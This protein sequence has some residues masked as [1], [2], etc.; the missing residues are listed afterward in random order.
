MTSQQR[1]SQTERIR[2]TDAQLSALE[3]SG[4]EIIDRDA[5]D[6]EDLAVLAAAWTG[7]TLTVTDATRESLWRAI[8]D[9]SNAEDA[10][11]E[12]DNDP[13]MRTFARRASRSLATLG[14]RVLRG[15]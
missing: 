14:S 1:T 11:A 12:Q 3:C 2:L 4:L 6:A 7:R 5:D 15:Q 9:R 13:A 8:N 10:A